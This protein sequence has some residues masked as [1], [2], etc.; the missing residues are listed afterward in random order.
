MFFEWPLQK[1]SNSETEFPNTLILRLIK[2]QYT[3]INI[4]LCH[5]NVGCPFRSPTLPQGERV[6]PKI[7]RLSYSN[8]Y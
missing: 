6:R 2:L 8:L 7:K 5:L 4:N 3:N 1:N